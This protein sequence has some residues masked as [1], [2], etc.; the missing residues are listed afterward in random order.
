M[1]YSDGVCKICTTGEIENID[2]LLLGC[3]ENKNFWKLMENIVQAA[4]GHIIHITLKEVISGYWNL[5]QFHS[6]SEVSMINVI[7]SIC[8]YH[9]WKIRNSIKYGSE[10]MNYTRR[11]RLLKYDLKSHL[12][13]LLT[14]GNTSD[15]IKVCVNSILNKVELIL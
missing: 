2:H 9:I 5:D 3:K 10:Q 4:F 8:R 15:E 6:P 11:L 12:Q 13:I 1:K 7:L 14:S